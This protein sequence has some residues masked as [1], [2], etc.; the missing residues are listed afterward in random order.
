MECPKCGMEIGENE[1]SCKNCG[2][3]IKLVDVSK[4]EEEKDEEKEEDSEEVS[5]TEDIGSESVTYITP[6]Q[7]VATQKKSNRGSM[8]LPISIAL[9]VLIIGFISIFISKQLFGKHGTAVSD[10]T[11][12]EDTPGRTSKKDSSKDDGEGNGTKKVEDPVNTEV[13]IGSF[14]FAIPNN[15]AVSLE[16]ENSYRAYDANNKVNLVFTIAGATDYQSFY[17]SRESFIKS[18]AGTKLVVKSYQEERYDGRTWFVIKGEIESV[19][20]IYAVTSIGKASTFHVT[21]VN[22]GVRTNEEVFNEV[23]KIVANVR[24]KDSSSGNNNGSSGNS[25][26]NNGSNDP[27]NGSSG[28]GSIPTTPGSSNSVSA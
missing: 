10:P 19:S 14:V 23:S 18:L 25:G 9:V 4:V 16:K 7:Y 22:L 26:S 5:E 21:I 17:A 3:R 20:T 2:E 28:N 8:I 11:V 12:I 15:Y 1:T 24:I 27:G 6:E 13:V